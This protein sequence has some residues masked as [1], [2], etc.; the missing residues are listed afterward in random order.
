MTWMAVTA[1]VCSFLL[2][3][4]VAFCCLGYHMITMAPSGSGSFV[5]H[6]FPQNVHPM[7]KSKHAP[8]YTRNIRSGRICRRSM[9]NAINWNTA[10]LP[11]GVVWRVLGAATADTHVPSPLNIG[12]IATTTWRE[13]ED[14]ARF[15]ITH[16][17]CGSSGLGG[18]IMMHD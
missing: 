18:S 3:N 10:W 16:C 14:R 9:S 13:T 15:V 2:R 5:E 4:G 8:G 6:S 1:D 12:C 17:R 11:V 7:R